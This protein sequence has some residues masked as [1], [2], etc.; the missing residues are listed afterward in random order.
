VGSS[1]VVPIWRGKVVTRRS[2]RKVRKQAGQARNT[3]AVPGQV[4]HTTFAQHR[5]PMWF[6][7]AAL[8]AIT[9]WP[10]ALV[11]LVQGVYRVIER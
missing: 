7:I 3:A 8:I 2:P 5:T 11:L 4:S 1:N 9:M 10:S 6:S